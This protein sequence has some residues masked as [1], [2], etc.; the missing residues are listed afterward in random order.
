MISELTQFPFSSSFRFHGCRE[1]EP[2]WDKD[3]AEDVKDECQ[4]K[5][6]PVTSIH[7]EKES[8]GEI[9]VTF[10]NLDASRKAL[11]G[12]NGRFFGG[13]PISAQ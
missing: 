10:A 7:V 5:Y 4:A 9:Y 11:D 8:A 3:L 12:L 13:K 2:D 1:T 6:G